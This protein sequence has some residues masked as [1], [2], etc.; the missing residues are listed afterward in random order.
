[1]N[2]RIRARQCISATVDHNYEPRGVKTYAIFGSDRPF[3]RT[4][5]DTRLSAHAVRD[6]WVP[7]PASADLFGVYG[8]GDRAAWALGRLRDGH[9]PVFAAAT[10][11][12]P[13]DS[14][15][16][17][18]HCQ[19][20]RG[21]GALGPMRRGFTRDTARNRSNPSKPGCKRVSA[22]AQ[23]FETLRVLIGPGMS[24]RTRKSQ[25]SNAQRAPGR[26]ES[27]KGPGGRSTRPDNTE[28]SPGFADKPVKKY[29]SNGM[30]IAARDR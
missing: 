23:A 27:V 16:C 19:A 21:G 25:F 13:P 7:L 24:R 9:C 11:G 18:R 22:T 30:F 20:M 6:R 26:P 12:A 15:P 17:R 3:H 8:R 14:I 29:V 5:C 4:L 1:M 2:C 28:R 10:L